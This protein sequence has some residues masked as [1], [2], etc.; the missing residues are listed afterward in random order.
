MPGDGTRTR[1]YMRFAAQYR[2]S[3]GR[4]E[5]VGGEARSPWMY[6]GSALFRHQEVGYTFSFDAPQADDTFV[7]RGVAD[8]QWRARRRHHG[9]ASVAILRSERLVTE[10]GHPSSGAEPAGYSAASCEIQGQP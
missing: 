4:W 6:A 7:F 10:S 5:F 1:M 8:F 2:D 9:K 3:D